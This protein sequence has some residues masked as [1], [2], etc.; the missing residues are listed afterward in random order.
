MDEFRVK[1]LAKQE[2]KRGRVLAV[3]PEEIVVDCDGEEFRCSLRGV[4]KR[5]K[6][7][8]KNLIVVGDF[9]LF[10]HSVIEE[11]CDR[12]SLLSRQ[13]HH[14]RRKKQLLAANIDQVLITTSV[15][16]PHLKP[17]LIDRYLIA[18]YKG[19]MEPVLVINKSDLID[20]P[21]YIKEIVD[22]Y[23]GLA[24]PVI[25]TSTTTGEGLDRLKEQMRSVASVFSGQSGVGKSSLINALLG[26]DLAVGEVVAKT[27]KGAHTTSNAQLIRL[28]C[29]GFCID[30]PGIRSFGIW[31]IQREDL[32]HHFPEIAEV[33]LDCRFP[34]CSH[35]HEPSC[36]V[37]KAVERGELSL[38][39]FESYLKLLTEI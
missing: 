26:T 29:G 39:R 30:T 6:S 16:Q 24:V 36:A 38:I 10:N 21:A 4:L 25:L 8:D 7:H 18:T 12:F 15:K 34:N 23:E 2:L 31:D 3:L 22:L 32:V 9:V 17:S 37:Q 33:G 27:E 14:L 35:T 28:D 5:K 19:D 1:R 11:V 13:E 20:D